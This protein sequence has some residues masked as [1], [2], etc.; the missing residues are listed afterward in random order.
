VLTRDI[1]T[2][3]LSVRLSVTFR[4]GIKI[5]YLKLMMIWLDENSL[6][7]SQFFPVAVPEISSC[8][9]TTGALQSLTGHTSW[10]RD[11]NRAC[12]PGPF[13]QTCVSGFSLCHQFNMPSLWDALTAWH[14]GFFPC[15]LRFTKLPINIKP[16]VNFP[17]TSVG[18]TQSG[19]LLS[20]TGYQYAY[21][22]ILLSDLK[23]NSICHI[24]LVPLLTIQRWLLA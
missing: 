4:W 21:R 1:D 23:Q 12:K 11:R 17:S 16:K 24:Y 22:Y 8:R 7:L 15:D 3:I 19:C 20:V 6:T 13:F 9:G 5:K 18:K 10:H 14:C 2:A